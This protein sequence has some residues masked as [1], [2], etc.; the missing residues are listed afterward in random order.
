MYEL[1]IGAEVAF[2]KNRI[3]TTVDVY[4]RNTFDLID[5]VRT[6]G[7]GGQYYKYANFGDMVA[8]GIEFGLHTINVNTNAWKWTTDL[9]FSAIHQ[10]ITRMLNSPNAFDMVAGR[11]RGNVVGYPKGSLFS[12]N[13]QR[14]DKNGL[15]NFNFGRYPL[16]KTS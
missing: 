14:L 11:G 16:P 10:Q 7:V 6:S 3:S 9:T 1:N 8:R 4:Q 13:F 15:P 5:L 12:F 2:L